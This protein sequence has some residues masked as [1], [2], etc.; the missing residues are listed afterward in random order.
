MS[1][2]SVCALS[3]RFCFHLY[4]WFVFLCKDPAEERV[5][6][7]VAMFPDL[8]QETVR[9]IV[10]ADLAEGKNEDQIAQDLLKQTGIRQLEI[11]FFCAA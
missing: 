8:D 5:A 9:N 3:V 10:T 4:L 7:F 6:S 1:S 2:H 11:C